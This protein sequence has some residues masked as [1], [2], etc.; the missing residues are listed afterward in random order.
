MSTTNNENEQLSQTDVSSS[1]YW[2]SI[3][4]SELF[5]S[6][7][8]ENNVTFEKLKNTVFGNTAIKV[9]QV[10][11]KG[12]QESFLDIMERHQIWWMTKHAICQVLA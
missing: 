11:R 6:A 4:T 2:D 9:I 1:A 3:K 5:L 10:V 8:K 12:G 7:L